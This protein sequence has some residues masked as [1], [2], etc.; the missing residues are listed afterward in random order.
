MFLADMG[1]EVIR[2]ESVNVF[3]TSTRGQFARPSK[4][5]QAKAPTSLYPNRDPGERPWNR[6]SLFNS[7]ARNKRSITV[8]LHTPEGKDVF[9]R[10]VEVSDVFV[11]NNALGSMERLGLTYPTVSGWNPR[12]IML[13][14]TGMGQTG[15]WAHFRG[16]GL[17]FEAIYGHASVTGYPD[18]DASG[19]PS[20]V[21]ADAA[22]GAAIAFSVVMALH[23]RQKTGKGAFIDLAQGEN[24]VHHLGE[25]FMDYTMNGRVAGPTANRDPLMHLVQ[26]CYP[27][28]GNDEHIVI[29]LESVDQWR[30]LCGLMGAPGLAEDER[31]DSMAGLRHHHDEVDRLIGA[32]TADQEPIGLFHR[33][34]GAGIAAGPVMHE[35]HAYADP[36]L[37]KRGF[38][39]T[40][41]HP[42]VGTHRYPSTAFKMSKAP[43]QVRR[44][45]VR[46]GE[47]ND[48]VYR[49]VLGFSEAEYDRLK[50][51]GQIGVDYAP[52]I[53]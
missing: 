46:L 49:E 23:R 29:S 32:W 25:I 33:L 14:S 35:E 40:V 21:A 31:F 7:H 36:H 20:S 22:A 3:P 47:D 12:I 44:P 19:T 24:F 39:A 8:D 4:E 15:P 18:M 52:H 17:H 5:A 38:F 30:D 6:T 51:L 34:Q 28:Q 53:R 9:R 16:F 1:A 2:V 27:C 41:T 13:S 43:F 26:G 11:E 10:L 45:P 37:E 50:G 48:Y 42:D